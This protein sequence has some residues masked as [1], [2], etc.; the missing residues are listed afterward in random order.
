MS[1]FIKH[2]HTPGC[3]LWKGQEGEHELLP[4]SLHNKTSLWV[5]LTGLED[6]DNSLSVALFKR[7]LSISCVLLRLVSRRQGG[8]PTCFAAEEYL[9]L[10]L[11]FLPREYWITHTHHC[12]QF[13]EVWTWTPESG[14]CQ[15]LCLLSY[16][17]TQRGVS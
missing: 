11:L 4:L 10:V 15:A 7:E 1:A 13:C 12:T 2:I 8:P 14:A 16:I 17:P 6:K 5:M 9:G 3:T